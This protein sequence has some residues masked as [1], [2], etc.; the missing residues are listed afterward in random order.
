MPNAIQSDYWYID[1]SR[2]FLVCEISAVSG[3]TVPCLGEL[4]AYV[5]Y[6]YSIDKDTNKKTLLYP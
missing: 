2:E 4:V 1:K 6:V 3:D 5:P